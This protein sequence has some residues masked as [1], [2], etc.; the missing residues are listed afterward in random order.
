MVDI[1]KLQS[2]LFEDETEEEEEVNFTSEQPLAHE[3]TTQ[4]TID[5][6]VFADP[7]EEPE[8]PEFPEDP[9]FEDEDEEPEEEYEEYK[10]EYTE[11]DAEDEPAEDTEEPSL[12][13]ELTAGAAPEED[14]E[15]PAAEPEE[16]VLPEEMEEA[17]L[18]EE[19]PVFEEIIEDEP[20]QEPS[21]E[22][23]IDAIVFGDSDGFSDIDDLFAEFA[24]ATDLDA[25]EAPEPEPKPEEPI[26]PIEP[27]TEP[28]E[29][30]AEIL[31]DIPV[32]EEE[33]IPEEKNETT[34]IVD[35]FSDIAG[36]DIPD[37]VANEQT[38]QLDLDAILAAPA[39]AEEEAE[40]EA[41]EEA[42]VEEEVDF[43]EEKLTIEEEPVKPAKKDGKKEFV[44]HFQ[45]IISPLFGTD[46]SE[47]QT[48]KKQGEDR[49]II[50][51]SNLEVHDD[52]PTE[53]LDTH[54]LKDDEE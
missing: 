19:L 41:V 1:K 43:F 33:D 7:E 8:E 11:E 45:P 15:E 29:E 54:S 20:V 47:S 16:D 6:A 3:N 12:F 35:F 31:R 28:E 18:A 34:N 44:Y 52:A 25:V 2:L 22:E 51:T 14:A 9:V 30:Q 36:E 53:I 4:I 46:L 24:A 23:K 21:I 50:V 32:S 17:P 42:P 10:E 26:F 5:P 38:T 39:Q 27:E 48:T 40:E 49:Q 13:D 37:N